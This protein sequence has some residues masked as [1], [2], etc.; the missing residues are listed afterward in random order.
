MEQ[1]RRPARSSS[2][3]NSASPT[4]GRLTRTLAAAP[5][6]AASPSSAAT[7]RSLEALT[8]LRPASASATATSSTQASTQRSGTSEAHERGRLERGRPA[9]ALVV[10]VAGQLH[11]G[12]RT[13]RRPSASS[14]ASTRNRSASRRPVSFAQAMEVGVLGVLRAALGQGRDHRH[15]ARRQAGRDRRGAAAAGH[16]RRRS[17]RVDEPARGS[18]RGSDRRADVSTHDCTGQRVA[19]RWRRARLHRDRRRQ[20]AGRRSRGGRGTGAPA[21]K[22]DDVTGGRG[23]RP[24]QSGRRCLGDPSPRTPMLMV[25]RVRRRGAGP[26]RRGRSPSSGAIGA[27]RSATAGAR[28]CRPRRASA[29]R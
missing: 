27:G 20:R 23:R 6:A 2:C 25:R 15:E 13:R 28:A 18:G 29:A 17:E 22:P 19:K 14:S 12:A 16:R 4:D 7:L 24:R 21:P 11:R 8:L 9:R 26:L 3:S 1:L 5:R 10:R